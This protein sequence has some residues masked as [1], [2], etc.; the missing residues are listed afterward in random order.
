MRT[1]RITQRWRY[2]SNVESVGVL[3]ARRIPTGSILVAAVVV[4]VVSSLRVLAH[5]LIIA[6]TI[7]PHAVVLA[8]AQVSAR[9]TKCS[10]GG[11]L[12]STAPPLLLC[13]PLSTST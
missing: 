7:V 6:V 1:V 3:H 8:M 11:D 9:D 10:P 2:L 12:S 13:P 4:V 5:V